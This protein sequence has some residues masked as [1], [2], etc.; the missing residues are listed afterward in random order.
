M[1]PG[2]VEK[3]FPTASQSLG[4]RYDSHGWLVENERGYKILDEHVGSRR[5]LR[6]V[7]IGAGA[8]GICFSKFLQDKLENVDLQ[9]YDK[10]ADVGGTWLENRQGFPQPKVPTA[11][12]QDTNT[13]V[14]Q[15][16]RLRL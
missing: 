4:P 1:S 5:K 3:G 16:P 6:V 13:C 10:N 12:G 9:I 8:S 14:Y 11:I 15:V 2:K 7:H